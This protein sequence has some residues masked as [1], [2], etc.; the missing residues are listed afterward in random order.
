MRYHW[1]KVHG[2]QKGSGAENVDL[3]QTIGEVDDKSLKGELQACKHFS[4]D[5]EMEN[6]THR[7]FNFA[8][9]TVNTKFFSESL[10]LVFE[11][12]KYAMRMIVAF[13]VLLKNIEDGSCKYWYAHKNITLL[14]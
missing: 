4:V 9:D 3:T 1:W 5:T 12:L 6:W 11:S 8:T 2:V 14:E 10:D 7:V 13:G